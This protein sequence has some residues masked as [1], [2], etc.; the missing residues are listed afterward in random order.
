MDG[1]RLE[2]KSGSTTLDVGY[3]NLSKLSLSR[4]LPLTR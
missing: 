3:T 4:R 1:V 2:F